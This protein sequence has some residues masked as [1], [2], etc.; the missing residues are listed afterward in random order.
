M[1]KHVQ[2][3]HSQPGR[4]TF[5]SIN[6]EIGQLADQVHQ[7]RDHNVNPEV[8]MAL[9]APQV[10]HAVDIEDYSS[11]CFMVRRMIGEWPRRFS[12]CRLRPMFRWRTES[13][14]RNLRLSS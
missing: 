11:D 5:I 12:R 1:G 2:A 6:V 10:G 7:R 14:G 4:L 9:V 3:N 8:L 13:I